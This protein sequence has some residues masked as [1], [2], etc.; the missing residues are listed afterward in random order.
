[1]AYYGTGFMQTN[2]NKLQMD[3]A[4]EQKLDMLTK[5]LTFK[6][7]GSYN[8]AYTVNKQGNASVA[9]YYPMIQSDGSILYRKEGENTVPGYSSSQGKA[10]DWYFE[11]SLNY[12][13]AFGEHSIS[14]LLLY[15]QSKQYY[16][17]STSQPDVPRRMSGRWSVTYDYRNRYIAESIWVTTA[18]RTLL[19]VVVLVRFRPVLS[20][21]WVSDETFFK[22]LGRW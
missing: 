3:L 13:R 4:L 17:S 14:A 9:A 20:A 11:G 18:P 22:P 6:L 15:N 16:Y 1:M 5:G 2:N 21:G 19:P 8:S 10:R 12:A 7:K